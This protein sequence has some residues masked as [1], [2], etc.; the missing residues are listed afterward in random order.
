MHHS[1]ILARYNI[2]QWLPFAF[3]VVL[4]LTRNPSMA[5]IWVMSY[6]LGLIPKQQQA[7]AMIAVAMLTIVRDMLERSFRDIAEN[8]RE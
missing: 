8:V 1:L 7:D 4:W 2:D 5:M 6:G 3:A